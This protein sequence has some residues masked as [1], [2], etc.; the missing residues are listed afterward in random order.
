MP[1]V[2]IRA[3]LVVIAVVALLIRFA[4]AAIVDSFATFTLWFFLPVVVIWICDSLGKGR[5]AF[6][7]TAVIVG[8]GSYLLTVGLYSR[9]PLRISWLTFI[10]TPVN[11]TGPIYAAWRLWRDKSVLAGEI[12]W[13]WMGLQWVVLL[14]CPELHRMHVGGS[15][16]LEIL[17]DFARVTSALAVFLALYGKRPVKPEPRWPHHLG[18]AVAECDV[19]AWGWYASSWL[20]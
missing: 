9:G 3:L 10:L 7:A 11:L 15:N 5:A 20:R 8:A 2:S 19:I 14:V 12:L 18:W 16:T 17:V 1:R 6:I 4:L 13:A